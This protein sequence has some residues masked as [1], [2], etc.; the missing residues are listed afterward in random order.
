[1]LKAERILNVSRATL[2]RTYTTTS[3]RE[4]LLLNYAAN[5]E[6]TFLTLNPSR[7]QLV[8]AP[9]NECSVRKFLPTTLRPAILADAALCDAS[10]L[11]TFV[12]NSIRYEPLE[13]PHLPP[14]Y[15]VSPQ[16][17]LEWQQ[18]DSFD[19]SVLLA[20]LLIGAGYNAY[21]CIGYADK[22][23]TE[24]ITHQTVAPRGEHFDAYATS[25]VRSMA[26]EAAFSEHPPGI[27]KVDPRYCQDYTDHTVPKPVFSPEYRLLERLHSPIKDV[28]AVSL[29]N[30]IGE[31]QNERALLSVDVGADAQLKSP[32]NLINDY[33]LLPSES[34]IGNKEIGGC[35]Y[36]LSGG[37]ECTDINSVANGCSLLVAPQFAHEEEEDLMA[38]LLEGRGAHRKRHPVF[39]K[40]IPPENASIGGPF[41]NKYLKPKNIMCTSEYDEQR[42][43]RAKWASVGA[44]EKEI[45][46]LIIDRLGAAGQLKDVLV[47]GKAGVQQ[48]QDQDRALNEIRKQSK[49]RIQELVTDPL[50]GQ[51]V[52]AWV[53]VAPTDDSQQGASNAGT[54]E[55]VYIEKD[56][57]A[58]RTAMSTPTTVNSGFFIDAPSGIPYTLDCPYF[59]FIESAFNTAN[60]FVNLQVSKKDLTNDNIS[61]DFYNIDCWCICLMTQELVDL[62]ARQLAYVNK[63]ATADQITQHVGGNQKFLMQLGAKGARQRLE[64][65]IKLPKLIRDR[66]LAMKRERENEEHQAQLVEERVDIA[67]WAKTVSLDKEKYKADAAKDSY[68]SFGIGEAA[69][70]YLERWDSVEPVELLL[71]SLPAPWA[72]ATALSEERL[73]WP[74][75]RRDPLPAEGIAVET[76]IGSI[77]EKATLYSDCFVRLTPP[78]NLRSGCVATIIF[79][80]RPVYEF[81][82]DEDGDVITKRIVAWRILRTQVFAHR[83]DRLVLRT[84]QLEVNHDEIEA[85]LSDPLKYDYYTKFNDGGELL[86]NLDIY[87]KLYADH[88]SYFPLWCFIGEQIDEMGDPDQNLTEARVSFTEKH[89][90][91]FKPEKKEISPIEIDRGVAL[92]AD[93]AV[94][95]GTAQPTTVSGVESDAEAAPV[96]SSMGPGTRL[97]SRKES[98]AGEY[99]DAESTRR[100]SGSALDG[101]V[102][103]TG[104]YVATF[105]CELNVTVNFIRQAFE[106]GREDFLKAHLLTLSDEIMYRKLWFYPG[107]EDACGFVAHHIGR[108]TELRYYSRLREDGLASKVLSYQTDRREGSSALLSRPGSKNVAE[109]RSNQ[110]DQSNYVSALAS[111]ALNSL[112]IIPETFAFVTMPVTGCKVVEKFSSVSTIDPYLRMRRRRLIFGKERIL[113]ADTKQLLRGE[114]GDV[115]NPSQSAT[116]TT[117][118]QDAPKSTHQESNSTIEVTQDPTE[119]TTVGLTQKTQQSGKGADLD[120]LGLSK[121]ENEDE[122]TRVDLFGEFERALS[123]AAYRTF[124]AQRI[125]FLHEVGSYY[126]AEY[127]L[128][129]GALALLSRHELL[130]NLASH[131]DPEQAKE[132]ADHTQ[133][134]GAADEYDDAGVDDDA[135]A[136]SSHAYE[137]GPSFWLQHSAERLNRTNALGKSSQVATTRLKSAAIPQARQES[138]STL[139]ADVHALLMKK[140]TNNLPMGVAA[141]YSSYNLGLITDN[142][143]SRTVPS[144][145]VQ[146]RPQMYTDTPGVFNAVKYV[147]LLKSRELPLLPHFETVTAAA[148][149]A[150]TAL[151]RSNLYSSICYDLGN[152]F[153]RVVETLVAPHLLSDART[154]NKSTGDTFISKTDLS[155]RHQ[156]V[157][158]QIGC[159]P[160]RENVV[161]FGDCL[162]LNT[163]DFGTATTAALTRNQQ[164]TAAQLSLEY[165]QVSSREKTTIATVRGDYNFLLDLLRAIECKSETKLPDSAF[166][167]TGH[168]VSDNA[169]ISVPQVLRSRNKHGLL[170]TPRDL[171]MA[172]RVLALHGNQARFDF[173]TTRKIQADEVVAQTDYLYV[174]LPDEYKTWP[175]TEPLPQNVAMLTRS[176]ALNTLRTRL[177]ERASI[178][179]SRMEAEAE[180]LKRRR[181]V[182]NKSAD[183]LSQEDRDAILAEIRDCV[184]RID[185]L[186]M[187]SRKHEEDSI[188]RFAELESRLRRDPR[189]VE[190]NL[191]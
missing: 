109:P 110:G 159:K 130:L 53:Y 119:D 181:A 81:G 2:P 183:Q 83:N 145:Y 113:E 120:P 56:I 65:G 87:H 46:K 170:F 60:Y 179:S 6:T 142:E 135:N 94:L 23:L 59:Q 9:Y 26:A 127:D 84:A 105:P 13:H 117:V 116:T 164:R 20:S 102:V 88:T 68:A 111:V 43:I 78:F 72:V 125:L 90:C 139:L 10:L 33:K 99:S 191:Q 8:L 49:I 95:T 100:L 161:P 85:D 98:L 144:F 45:E 189:L 16:T 108:S 154:F 162:Q 174:Y 89:V 163:H 4:E 129:C 185:I 115:S 131:L 138:T 18:G 147:A 63:T 155:S 11:A 12:A 74:Y 190:L 137:N 167:V 82:A 150:S 106:Y 173:Q 112:E 184:F 22:C 80:P 61:F 186:E 15:V 128:N 55:R 35:R 133:K 67:R 122:I 14:D 31:L 1:M 141:L 107:R 188:K 57:N 124:Q 151:K 180:H 126:S 148:Q 42:R 177:V 66:Q 37:A 86:T 118:T 91:C 93:D 5:F 70:K 165:A 34:D 38:D 114:Q 58:I 182:Y 103:E 97:Q 77:S 7:K 19:M 71:A 149:N 152:S 36:V 158:E 27:F 168:N 76:G 153:I 21:V 40:N 54:V 64:A 176:A 166:T 104:P 79:R 62:R 96:V 48:K 134:G 17:T 121:L 32:W 169:T 143:M 172:R 75:P 175:L 123:A 146:F 101:S 157:A 140:N 29:S 156:Y 44:S 41:K 30:S 39:N 47:P 171:A 28:N 25:T 50:K 132:F 136:E 3:S 73:Q 69:K 52:Y 178:I 92:D 51:R 187:R 24:Q 160:L